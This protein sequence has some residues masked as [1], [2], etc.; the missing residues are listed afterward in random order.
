M[1]VI[2]GGT[3]LFGITIVIIVEFFWNGHHKKRTLNAFLPLI[4]LALN[5]V[6]FWIMWYWSLFYDALL[7]IIVQAVIFGCGFL[8]VWGLERWMRR[9]H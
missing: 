9:V 2:D 6:W 4:P 8:T 3:Y 7:Y 5:A 1:L